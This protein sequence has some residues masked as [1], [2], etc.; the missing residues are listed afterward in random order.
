[1]VTT[2]Q[3]NEDLKIK[4]DELKIHHRETYNELISRII[5]SFPKEVDRES[6]IETV[7]IISDPESMRNIAESLERI[8]KN[9]LG[10]SWEKVKKDLDLNV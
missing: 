1:M 8:E 5:S 3:I 2:I 7:E 9:E 10:V 4:L 6:L